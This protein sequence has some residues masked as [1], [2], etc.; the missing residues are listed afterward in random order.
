MIH[1]L[2]EGRPASDGNIRN[3]LGFTDGEERFDLLAEERVPSGCVE[4]HQNL[5]K[6]T[7]LSLAL[8]GQESPL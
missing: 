5:L 3:S 8:R 7:G 4:R 1:H 2:R 6:K